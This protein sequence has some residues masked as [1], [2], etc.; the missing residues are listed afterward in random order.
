MIVVLLK[1]FTTALS[2]SAIS[3]MT[4]HLYRVTFEILVELNCW[5]FSFLSGITQALP[6]AQKIHTKCALIIITSKNQTSG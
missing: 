3:T 6:L 1:N 2:N 4:L 5:C